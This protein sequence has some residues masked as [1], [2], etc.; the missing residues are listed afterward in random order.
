[1]VDLPPLRLIDA[2][3]TRELLDL[4]TSIE[5]VERAFEARALSQAL[6]TSLSH[7][8]APNGEF[9]IKAGGLKGKR[10]YFAAKIN[11]GFF[12]NRAR[13]GWPNILGVILL[14]DADTGAPLALM[15]S[16]HATRLRTGAATAVAARYLVRKDSRTLTLCGSGVQAAIQLEALTRV[17]DLER[18][19]VW[20]R[21]GGEAFCDA[22]R[23]KFG[24]EFMPAEDLGS[25]VGQSDVIVACTPATQWFLGRDM[26]RPGTFVAAVGADSPTKQE[27]EPALLAASSVF[28][29]VTEQSAHVGDLHHAIAAGLMAAE[30]VRGELGEVI[31]GLKPGRV[32]DDETIVFDSTGTA[33]QDVAVA[34]AIYER[35]V[36]HDAGQVV[37][38][39]G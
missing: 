16:G 27:L 21:S 7:V 39:L 2:A 9:H 35:A 5:A 28:T 22:Q 3:L 33:L 17:L 13:F 29:D 31:A 26:V 18:V 12:G 6:P 37:R 10:S 8:D 20:A 11:G 32:S 23:A 34:A 14:S 1:M 19:F 36:A 38:L 30:D 4:E 15:E 24:L 25:A